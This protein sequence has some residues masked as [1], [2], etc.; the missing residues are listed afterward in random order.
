MIG[1]LATIFEE[2]RQ[3]LRLL[4]ARSA[5]HRV[6]VLVENFMLAIYH[7]GT[8]IEQDPSLRDTPELAAF[9]QEL[10][11]ALRRSIVDL[12]SY[13][14]AVISQFQRV[15]E[16]GEWEQ[17]SRLRSAIQFF[18]ELMRDTPISE[19]LSELDTELDDLDE[20]VRKWGKRE[21][22]LDTTDPGI[23]RSHWWWRYP[24]P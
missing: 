13:P 21:G 19:E 15:W 20:H 9:V 5:E 3:D 14:Q 1:P 7:L 17:L 11:P 12:V 6:R 10:Q 16:G 4:N 24:E 22:G 23:P 18:V 2:V 8:A